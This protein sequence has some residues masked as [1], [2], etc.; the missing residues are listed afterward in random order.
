[1]PYVAPIETTNPTC[2][3]FL[4][5]RSQSMLQTMGGGSGRT[6]AEAVADTLNS[7]LF[8]LVLR[9]VADKA[10]RDRFHVGVLGYGITVGPALGGNLTGRELMPISELANNP[11][12]ME[13]RA[14][15]GGGPAARSP[16]WFEPEGMGQTPTC[17]TLERA[18]LI[19][20]GFLAQHPDCFP[21]VVIHLTDGVATDGD[22]EGPADRLRALS[23]GDGNVLLVNAHVSIQQ[24]ASVTFP[25][26]E[27]AVTDPLARRLFRMSSVL[28]PVMRAMGR[29]LGFPMGDEARGFVFNADLD[30]VVQFMNVG[31][32]PTIHR[33]RPSAAARRP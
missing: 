33:S 15:A 24:G 32:S 23:S 9:C 7:F 8:N 29:E 12:R 25:D 16:V 13:H 17:T 4:I 31:T 5:D 1:M 10:V 11:L 18:R 28:P 2:F 26:E 3:L 14:P 27:D 21:P 19:V 30:A 6:K 22:P 20:A